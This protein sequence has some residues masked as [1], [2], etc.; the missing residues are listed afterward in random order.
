[1][2]ILNKKENNMTIGNFKIEKF[3]AP[4]FGTMWTV[5]NIDTNEELG[6]WPTKESAIAFAKEETA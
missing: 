2:Y 4:F 1:M 3:E 5:R 6:M